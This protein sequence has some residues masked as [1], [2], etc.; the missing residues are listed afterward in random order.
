MK[1]KKWLLI[2]SV[3][4]LSFIG[5]IYYLGTNG[6]YVAIPWSILIIVLANL[7]LAASVI[8]SSYKIGRRINFW[9]EKNAV[10]KRLEVTI[11]FASKRVNEEG[12]NLL[13]HGVDVKWAEP[14][15]REA[16]LKE[17]KIV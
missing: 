15:A 10:E 8:A 12:V 17:D 13:P 4:I 7:D 14:K 6:I 16:F 1:F 3:I 9:F 11:A 2:I 5:L